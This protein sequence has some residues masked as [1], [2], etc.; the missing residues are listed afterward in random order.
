[1]NFN[2]VF[3]LGNLTRDPELRTTPSG[4]SV[5]SFG[6][7]TNRIWIDKNGQKQKETEFHNVIAWGKLAETAS[8]YLFKGKLVFVEGRL[9]TRSWVDQNGV[10]HS[11]TE[12]IAQN[13][14]LGPKLTSEAPKV[15]E[16]FV[17]PL[18]EETPIVEEELPLEEISPEEI[19]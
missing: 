16:E 13:F 19:F 12:I 14:Q 7:A 9:R 8:R 3:I 10:K 15:E 5:V 4:Q 18:V 2:K 17:E 11:R 1:M 6:V